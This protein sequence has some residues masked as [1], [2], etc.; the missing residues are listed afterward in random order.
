MQKL[1]HRAFELQRIEIEVT[2]S[3]FQATLEAFGHCGL[4]SVNTNGLGSDINKAPDAVGLQHRL[5]QQLIADLCLEAPLLSTAWL[6]TH[7]LP[8]VVDSLFELFVHGGGGQ[9]A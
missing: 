1:V 3:G 2:E 8:I 5:G 6:F 4:R 7:A 9:Y